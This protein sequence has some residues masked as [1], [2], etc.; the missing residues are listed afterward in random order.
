[1]R[2]VLYCFVV[3]CIIAAI[4]L[5]S[6]RAQ[7]EF[8]IKPIEPV[9][10]VIDMGAQ[11]VGDPCLVGNL[12]PA[13]NGV[14]GWLLP[15]AIKFAFDPVTMGDCAAICPVQPAF[16]ID[17][18]VI[19]LQFQVEAACALEL[20]VDVEEVTYPTGPDCPEPGDVVCQS[21]VYQADLP[22]AGSWIVEIPIE[23]ACLTADKMYMIGAR[24]QS[25]T[26]DFYI[27]IDN[28][29]TVCTNWFEWGAGWNDLVSDLNFPGNLKLW[30]EATCC[31]PPVPVES[32]TW[33]AIKSLYRQ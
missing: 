28:A 12:N 2:R 11:G 3:L 7:V 21:T 20:E 22:Q 23:C 32:K 5:S 29:P 24:I 27:A 18:K 17:I 4:P 10:G 14:A 9:S 8:T 13:V 25:A 16:G 1:M 15:A 6:V 33:G 19:R 31:E 26:C 30:A